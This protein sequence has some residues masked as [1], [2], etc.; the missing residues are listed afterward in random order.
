VCKHKEVGAHTKSVPKYNTSRMA[1]TIF[2]SLS[3][4]LLQLVR[5]LF[6]EC[7]YVESLGNKIRC[8]K[9]E[10]DYE[11]VITKLLLDS[12]LEVIKNLLNIDLILIN[13]MTEYFRPCEESGHLLARRITAHINKSANDRD[14]IEIL[15]RLRLMNVS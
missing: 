3:W 7:R 2:S 14:L 11:C 1:I 9:G 8:P 12:S 4:A 10:L 6:A 15:N 5:G 13:E